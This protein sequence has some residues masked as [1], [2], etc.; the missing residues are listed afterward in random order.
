MS[1]R[2]ALRS[3]EALGIIEIR[4][5]RGSFV[6]SELAPV[7]QWLSMH[8]EE[9]VDLLK[10][11][12]AVERLAAEEAARRLGPCEP[13]EAVRS[14]C[15]L[16]ERRGRERFA[17]TPRR[18][19][20]QVPSLDPRRCEREPARRRADGA[21][22]QSSRRGAST[23][24]DA[25]GPACGSP[26]VSMTTSCKLCWRATHRLR[27]APC[28]STC[29]P[30]R[31]PSCASV[32]GN[33]IPSMARVDEDRARRDVRRFFSGAPTASDGVEQTEAGRLRHRAYRRRGRHRLRR[34]DGLKAWGGDTA[35][36]TAKTRRRRSS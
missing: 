10:V 33:L 17:R 30:S 14:P 29:R 20:R 36:T 4:R 1:I 22:E 11:R 31:M 13:H 19:G 34:G 24:D 12:G 32:E 15:R 9:V 25:S 35:V 27:R 23:D 26:H 2:E 5:G 18:A 21:A 3:L 8:S 16:R 7:K 6:T 28:A